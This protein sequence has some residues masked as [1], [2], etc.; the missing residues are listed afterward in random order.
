LPVTKKKKKSKGPLNIAKRP[1]DFI[2]TS[3]DVKN[4]KRQR[5]NQRKEKEIKKIERQRAAKIKKTRK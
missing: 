3:E 5:E 1:V 2:L 4:E